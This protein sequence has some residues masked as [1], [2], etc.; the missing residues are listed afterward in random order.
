MTRKTIAASLAAVIFAASLPAAAMARP[1]FHGRYRD[2]PALADCPAQT[3]LTADQKAQLDK[4]H[5]EHYKAVTPLRDSLREKYMTLN[6]L[7]GNPNASP[8]EI[9]Q[10]TAD[11]TK[12]RTQ[13]RTV[14]D[15]FSAKL[16]K[17]GLPCPRNGMGYGRHDGYGMGYGHRGYGHDGYGH[18]MGRGDCLR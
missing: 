18:G 9:R 11:I 13:I 1:D 3:Q 16:V 12:L 14:N 2:C 4:F 5:E 6:A 17:A 8:D 7:S 15:D 10:L